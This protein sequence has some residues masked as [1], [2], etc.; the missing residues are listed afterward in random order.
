MIQHF[1]KGMIFEILLKPSQLAML[2]YNIIFVV[3][4]LKTLLIPFNEMVEKF[5]DRMQPLAN[6]STIVPMKV[7]FGEFTQD[8]ISKVRQLQLLSLIFVS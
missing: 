7:H 5:L 4:Y 6:G 2:I 1:V 3:S 8:V